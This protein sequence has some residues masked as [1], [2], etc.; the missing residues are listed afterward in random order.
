MGGSL[1]PRQLRGKCTR[2]RTEELSIRSKA[3]FV[4]GVLPHLQIEK[5]WKEIKIADAVQKRLIFISISEQRAK[6]GEMC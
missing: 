3:T 6:Q 1:V 2:E 4:K 5:E